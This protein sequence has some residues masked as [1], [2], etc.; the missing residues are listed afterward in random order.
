MCNMNYK[1]YK[2][3]KGKCWRCRCANGSPSTSSSNSMIRPGHI[4]DA[5][6]Q[7]Y[8]DLKW[9][10]L[11]KKYKLSLSWHT[12]THLIQYHCESLSSMH[13]SKSKAQ[14]CFNAMLHDLPSA[15]A[16]KIGCLG[17]GM[18]SGFRKQG[19]CPSGLPEL[20]ISMIASTQD[21]RDSKLK[22][23][24]LHRSKIAWIPRI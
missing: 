19:N 11:F 12:C 18:G 4:F 1:E 10:F 2:F 22:V 7:K 16:Q 17:R 24:R 20:R 8:W 15:K 13:C 3:C 21:C 5:C 23:V 14:I 6:P 9:L